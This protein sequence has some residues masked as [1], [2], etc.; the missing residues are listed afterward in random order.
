MI[1]KKLSGQT[2][3]RILVENIS[4]HLPSLVSIKNFRY[5]YKEGMKVYSR[6]TRKNNLDKLRGALQ[7]KNWDFELN[8][9]KYS[10]DVMTF[11][12]HIEGISPPVFQFPPLTSKGI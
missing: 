2:E 7:G 5:T 3:S 10:I 9:Y 6:D 8:S 1:S 11:N 4:D 12:H